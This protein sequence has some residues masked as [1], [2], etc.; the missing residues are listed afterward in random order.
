MDLMT[1]KLDAQFRKA[2]AELDVLQA[3]AEARRAKEDMDEISG[4]RTMRER[5]KQKLAD[6]KRK[7]SENAETSRR[8]AES[9]LH[10]LQA[11]IKRASER[12]RRV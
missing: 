7:A 8:E 4:L 1:D 5:A 9:A 3:Q 10:E 12:L 2:E 11:G 6:M